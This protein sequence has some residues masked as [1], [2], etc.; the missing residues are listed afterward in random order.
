MSTKSTPHIAG[1]YAVGST[2]LQVAPTFATVGD[3]MMHQ[4]LLG[5]PALE[6]H[7]RYLADLLQFRDSYEY[8][9]P[10]CCGAWSVNGWWK[11]RFA[12]TGVPT[13]TKCCLLNSQSFNLR[14]ES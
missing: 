14:E 3:D 6:Q 13:Y 7:P 10:C 5:I 2:N 9:C 12:T 1:T 8:S 11:R 4:Y